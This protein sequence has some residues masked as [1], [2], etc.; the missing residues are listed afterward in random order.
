MYYK[1]IKNQKVIDILDSLQ[2][3]KYQLK[4]RVLLFCDVKEAQG[5]L[6]SDGQTAYHTSEY[7]PFPCDEFETVTIEEI[8]ESEYKSLSRLHLMTPEDIAQE[9][10]MDLMKRGAL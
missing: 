3:V 4:H 1:V 5:V 9:V 6:S 2:Y 10:I 7:L 8:T